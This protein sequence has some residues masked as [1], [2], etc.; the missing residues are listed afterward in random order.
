MS[1]GQLTLSILL[2]LKQRRERRIRTA[3]ARI[4]RSLQQL[5][6]LGESLMQQRQSLWQQW[7]GC[8]GGWLMTPEEWQQLRARLASYYQQDRALMEQIEL[9]KRQQA[10]LQQEKQHQQQ[11]L[12]QNQLEQEKLKIIME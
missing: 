7:R 1:N 3:I 11:T 2:S 6:L 8:G 4:E 12:R 9:S 5:D 10:G